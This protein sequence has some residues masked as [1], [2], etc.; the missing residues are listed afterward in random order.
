MSRVQVVECRIDVLVKVEEEAKEEEDEFDELT[1]S[2]HCK[3]V[4]LEDLNFIKHMFS[5]EYSALGSSKNHLVSS[6]CKSWD[7]MQIAERFATAF[8]QLSQGPVE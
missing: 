6:V 8:L 3:V 4:V 1:L 7:A 2:E 5:L